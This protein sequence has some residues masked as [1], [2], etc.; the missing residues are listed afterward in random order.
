MAPTPDRRQRRRSRRRRVE[1]GADPAATANEGR[2]ALRPAQSEPAP[3]RHR[4]RTRPDR[5]RG[6]RFACA[7]PG[8][9][10]RRRIR[11]PRSHGRPAISS[12]RL[13]GWSGPHLET[14]AGGASA[15]SNG[16]TSLTF[17]FPRMGAAWRSDRQNA[18][19]LHWPA[20]AGRSLRA[21]RLRRQDR[22]QR[23]ERGGAGVAVPDRRVRAGRQRPRPH[24][25]R[26]PELD[27]YWTAVLVLERWL[28]L[29]TT[30][31][32]RPIINLVV[33]PTIANPQ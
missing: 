20:C 33:N 5:H 29:L 3:L 24:A 13:A 27:E 15:I 23:H 11:P 6:R 25:A 26:T 2:A 22:H 16:W 21:A 14:G 7:P 28:R 4:Q 9:L 18:G 12:P 17:A 30:R 10:R 32:R 8:R 19:Q 31:R 1:L